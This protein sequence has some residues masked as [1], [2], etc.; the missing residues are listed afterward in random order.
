MVRTRG[1]RVIAGIARDR[2]IGR[3]M[4][5]RKFLRLA[6]GA[7]IASVA[8]PIAHIITEPEPEGTPI[9]VSGPICFGYLEGVTQPLYDVYAI[10]AK[11]A[12]CHLALFPLSP[13]PSVSN[14]LNAAFTTLPEEE[15]A[16]WGF[17]P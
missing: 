11:P 4:D 17:W 9:A 1:N 12:A 10:E 7:A 8:A 16:R 3:N 2:V 5:R 6:T 13:D 15:P 14:V